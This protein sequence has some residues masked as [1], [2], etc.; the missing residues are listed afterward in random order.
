MQIKFIKLLLRFASPF[1][2][3]LALY[4]F[5][6]PFKVIWTYD[7]F[8]PEHVAG[9]VSLNPGYVGT[10]NYLRRQPQQHYDSFIMGNSRSI[11]YPV[12]DWQ[13]LL[14]KDS[15]CY[16]YDAAAESLMGIWQKLQLIERNNG[17]ID[18][19]LMVVDAE[20]LKK[21][22]CD[23]WHLCET[24]PQLAGYSNLFN[25]HWYN[26]KTFITPKFLWAYVDYSLFHKLRPYMLEGHLLT[27]DMFVYDPITNECNFLPMERQ[28]ESGTYYTE[29]RLKV[30]EN[31]QFPDSISPIAIQEKQGELLDSICSVFKRKHSNV[32]IV[33]SP[34]YNQIKI[35]PAD[36]AELSRRF[37]ANHIHDFSGP[38]KWNADYHNYFE[39]SH[40]RTHVCK[41]IFESIKW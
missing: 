1:A 9:G 20:L 22:E 30:F 4:L 17:D 31:K 11:Y 13:H 33:I 14:P 8:Y 16:H 28:I 2:V 6:D 37:G 27:E 26:F 21:T 5:A 36:K 34:L 29:E 38:N 3:L 7:V 18:N 25:F 12:K 32:H 35:N 24:A 15:H 40:Y 39:A 23:H 41:E 10:Q 19:V